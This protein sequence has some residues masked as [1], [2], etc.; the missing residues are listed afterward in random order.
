MF[1]NNENKKDEQTT[2]PKENLI[3]PE[4]VELLGPSPQEENASRLDFTS[5][6][7]AL[8]FNDNDSPFL[9]AFKTFYQDKLDKFLE[10]SN[11]LDYV[12]INKKIIIKFSN[13]GRS[14][15]KY[16]YQSFLNFKSKRARLFI[17]II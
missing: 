14:F 10:N 13:L 7:D 6:S 9:N 4:K 17:K 11:F 2:N 8:S 1:N 12:T 16:H 3:S 5:H 15:Q